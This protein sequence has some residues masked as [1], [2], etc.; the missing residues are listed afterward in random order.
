MQKGPVSMDRIAISKDNLKPFFHKY[1]LG[2]VTQVEVALE[3][4][5]SKQ[6]VSRVFNG[7][8]QALQEASR[9]QR[10][11]PRKD[12]ASECPKCRESAKQLFL[13]KTWIEFLLM[14]ISSF[15]RQL[16]IDYSPFNCRLS[17]KVKLFLLKSWFAYRELGGKL[18]DFAQG[19][20]RDPSTVYRWLKLYEAGLSLDDKPYGLKKAPRVYPAWVLKAVHKLKKGYP[21]AEYT[22]LA[23]LF[24][25]SLSNPQLKLSANEIKRILNQVE[26]NKKQDK[27]RRLKLYDFIKA[28]VS[29][30]IDFMEFTFNHIRR[31]ALIVVDHHSRKLLY[32]RVMLNPT[33]HK[34]ALV[35]KALTQHYKV[36]PQLVKADNGPEFRKQFSQLLGD[37]GITLLNSPVY[38]P[39]FNGVVERV[40]RE[41]RQRSYNFVLNSTKEID[42]FLSKFQDYYNHQ[43]H[44][45]LGGLTPAQVYKK[46]F[47]GSHPVTTEIVK[48]YIKDGELRLKFTGGNGN[49]SRLSFPMPEQGDS[50][51]YFFG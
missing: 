47:N 48:P 1:E 35:I 13:L 37:V 7:F 8:Q 36:V 45:S 27:A 30:D 16:G 43:V 14:W 3:L 5:V 31:R 41:I 17:G 20:H 9:D 4:G 49:P 33:S 50:S 44:A 6:Y 24:N 42:H 21:L 15:T 19:I 23:K 38:Y 32:A 46:K 10:G 2:M 11:R 39:Q 51:T 22:G 18:A 29:W 26:H 40:I 34:V 28:N 12:S 25:H